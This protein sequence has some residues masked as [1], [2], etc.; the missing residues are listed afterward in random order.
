MQI[1]RQSLTIAG[2]KSLSFSS[3]GK[4]YRLKYEE[5]GV[6]AWCTDGVRILVRLQIFQSGQRRWKIFA[7]LYKWA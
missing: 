1:N 7:V 3:Y 4:K 2:K 6:G 5:V